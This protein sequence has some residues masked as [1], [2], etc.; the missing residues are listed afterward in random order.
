MRDVAQLAGVSK[1]TVSRVLSGSAGVSEPLR[2]RVLEVV[3]QLGY[4]PSRV[5]RSLRRPS[6]HTIGLILSDIGNPFFAAVVRGIEE[7]GCSHGYSL[8]LCNSNEDQTREELY[9]GTLLAEKV[10]GVIVSPVREDGLT[11]EAL[12]QN[13][14]PVVAMDRRLLRF[15]VDTVLVDNVRGTFAAVDHLARLGHS[16]IGFVS[17]PTHTTT[18]RER[19][20]GYERALEGQG[21]LVDRE[22]VL[23][24]DF[25]Q[26]SGYDLTRELLHLANPPTAIFAANNLMTLGAL[27]A[28]HEQGLIIP[29]DIALAGFDDMPWASLL[30]PSLTVVAQPTYELGETAAHLLLSRIADASLEVREVQLEP[31]LIVRE[32]CGGAGAAA[33]SPASEPWWRSN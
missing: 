3:Q 17:G 9:V 19:L 4:Q 8:V 24:G 13:S 6:S 27:Q 18:G 30:H 33:V 5:A 25:K 28:I 10:A 21:L 20:E 7:L 26:H 12:I 31:R 1:A 2:R 14:I 29:R 23:A 16:R 22:L 32:S 15:A 11:C